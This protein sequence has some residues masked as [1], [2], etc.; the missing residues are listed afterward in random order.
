MKLVEAKTII[1]IISTSYTSVLNKR[2]YTYR[3]VYIVQVREF[4]SRSAI[5]FYCLI[6]FLPFTS[7]GALIPGMGAVLRV[8]E[9]K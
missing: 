2:T 8:D 6:R 4:R 7:W 9:L 1:V 5:F 3:I